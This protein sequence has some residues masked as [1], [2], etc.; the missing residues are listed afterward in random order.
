[1]GWLALFLPTHGLLEGEPG[2]S[3]RVG[4][5]MTLWESDAHNNFWRGHW[6]LLFGQ[7][8]KHDIHGMVPLL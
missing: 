4:Q 5:W 7:V 1:M 6:M 8:A 3:D 2:W